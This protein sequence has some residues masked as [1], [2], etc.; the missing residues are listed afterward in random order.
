MSARCLVRGE[1]TYPRARMVGPAATR[2]ECEDFSKKLATRPSN[3]IAQPTLALSTCPI[4]TEALANFE[5]RTRA[6]YEG[7]DHVISLGEVI[8]MRSVGGG[9]PLLYFRGGYRNIAR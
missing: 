4:L 1:S 2:K 7:G 5:C 8:R 9:R 3:Y 6:T